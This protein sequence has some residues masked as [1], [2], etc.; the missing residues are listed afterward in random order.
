[1]DDFLKELDRYASRVATEIL[2]E[3]VENCPIRTGNLISTLEI[4]KLKQCEYEVYSDCPYGGFVNY[5]TSKQK[6]NP[7]FS[8]AIEEVKRKNVK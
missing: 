7:F 3:A 5:G 2:S 8:N 4:E 1:M 6:P